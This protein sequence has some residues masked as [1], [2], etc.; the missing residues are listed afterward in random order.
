MPVLILSIEGK[1]NTTGTD[2][3]F[4]APAKIKKRVT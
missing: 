2:P 3:G 4:G 1:T